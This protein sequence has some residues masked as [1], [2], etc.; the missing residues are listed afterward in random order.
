MK[1]LII[2]SYGRC[3]TNLLRRMVKDNYKTEQY[4]DMNTKFEDGNLYITHDY[5]KEVKGIKPQGKRITPH[6]EL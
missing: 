5:C 2:A 4:C 1:P 6:L 3:G